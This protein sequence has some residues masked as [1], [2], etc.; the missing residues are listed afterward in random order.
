MNQGRTLIV[1]PH[2]DDEVLGCGGTIAKLSGK[3]EEV[4]VLIV[5]KGDELFDQDLIK[6]G[7]EEAIKA[8]RL[9]GVKKTHFADLPAIKL[10]TL[11]QYQINE[12]LLE[13]FTEIR[14]DILFL[15]F[16]GD[17]NR[18]HQIVHACGMVAARPHNRKIKSIYSY[19]TLS[20]TNWNSPVAAS[21]FVPNMFVDISDTI[22]KKIE[23]MNTYSS[24]LGKYPHPRSAETIIALSRYRGGFVHLH[25]A[26]AF[27]C[28]RDLKLE[29]EDF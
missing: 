10:D 4:H 5:T 12:K 29:A 1:A 13:Y 28:V 8:H 3:G 21:P 9:L 6:R 20:A 19:E 24:Q 27:V 7:R 18:D 16:P 23:A 14:P 22:N 15:P 11:P 17:I 2:P 26:E 25:H